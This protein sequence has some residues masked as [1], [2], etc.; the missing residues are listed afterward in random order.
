[1]H[2]EWAR[3]GWAGREAVPSRRS[4]LWESACNHLASEEHRSCWHAVARSTSPGVTRK[5]SEGAW[6]P[7]QHQESR[8]MHLSL[9]FECAVGEGETANT[10]SRPKGVGGGGGGGGTVG[11]GTESSYFSGRSCGAISPAAVVVAPVGA[12]A[13]AAKKV[14]A[15][16]HL[17]SGL[18]P[19]HPNPPPSPS[20][21]A[22]L[23]HAAHVALAHPVVGAAAA[24]FPGR[25]FLAHAS[26]AW[27]AERPRG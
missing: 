19:A 2:G 16:A 15:V 11:L 13:C 4:V 10:Q 3:P 1:M 20:A 12:G 27:D 24:N 9:L 17:P 22:P 14:A 7:S 25:P 26:S 6:R 8:H 23:P 21:A 18:P 5:G